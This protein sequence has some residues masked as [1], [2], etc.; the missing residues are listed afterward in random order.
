[1]AAIDKKEKT[2]E[3]EHIHRTRLLRQMENCTRPVL[4]LTGP[5]GAGKSTLAGAYLATKEQP[6][7][8][9]RFGQE[10]HS[11]A[12]FF[13]AVGKGQ[14]LPP[15]EAGASPDPTAYFQQLFDAIKKRHNS[16]CIVYLQDYHKLDPQDALTRSWPNWRWRPSGVIYNC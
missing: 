15:Y 3:T 2:G 11:P 7:I 1:M 16:P 6:I 12:T 4:W 14:S 5:P 10:N 9:Y 13:A 8:H